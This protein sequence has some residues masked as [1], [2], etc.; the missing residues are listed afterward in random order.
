MVRLVLTL[1]TSTQ[2]IFNTLPQINIL[3]QRKSANKI[4][5]HATVS[6]ICI[7]TVSQF[8]HICCQLRKNC[9][10]GEMLKNLWYDVVSKSHISG[11]CHVGQGSKYE[12][13]HK[14]QQRIWKLFFSVI[15]NPLAFLTLCLLTCSRTDTPGKVSQL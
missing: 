2:D 11:F 7:P 13:L 14:S 12:M 8:R 4:Q 5:Q 6:S 1:G 15:D 3:T 9:K 10:I